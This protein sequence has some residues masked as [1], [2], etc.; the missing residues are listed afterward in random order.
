MRQN[1]KNDR[2]YLKREHPRGRNPVSVMTNTKIYRNQPMIEWLEKNTA[3]VSFEADDTL[4]V[5]I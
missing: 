1:L 3:S 5:I 4:A 2:A